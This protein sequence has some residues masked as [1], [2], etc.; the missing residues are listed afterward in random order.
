M[1]QIYTGNGKGKTTAAVGL[2]VRAHGHGLRVAVFQFLKTEGENGEAQSLGQLGIFCRH[3]GSGRWLVN[4]EPDPEELALAAKGWTEI[5]TAIHSG[6]QIIVLD[7]IS[8]AVNLGL[9]SVTQVC[10]LVANLPADVELILTG[11]EMPEQ[12][13]NLADLVTE[14][15]AVKHPYTRGIGARRGIEF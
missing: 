3:Y 10:S 12:L 5:Q 6:Y 7:E 14:M 11:R 4:R 2:A 13:I 8:H 1:I 9:L 15:Q